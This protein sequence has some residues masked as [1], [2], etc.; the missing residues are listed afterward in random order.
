MS[1]CQ[2]PSKKTNFLVG[3]GGGGV[4]DGDCTVLVKF[5]WVGGSCLTSQ[6]HPCWVFQDLLE[7]KESRSRNGS[8]HVHL[9]SG[10]VNPHTIGPK[11]DYITSSYF[12]NL[13]MS[14]VM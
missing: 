3:A 4:N 7:R 1:L 13:I 8:A 5:G 11:N 14:D 2:T 10:A 12:L 9:D 6:S